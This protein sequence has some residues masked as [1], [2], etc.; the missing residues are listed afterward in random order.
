M[1]G[2]SAVSLVCGLLTA[3]SLPCRR[4]QLLEAL[5]RARWGRLDGLGALVLTPTR[6]LAMQVQGEL[7][8]LYKEAGARIASCVGGMDSRAEQ[9]MLA[10]GAHIVVGTPGRLRDH[11]ERGRLDLGSLRVAV[12]DGLC[13]GGGGARG[14]HGG[15][16]QG[17]RAEVRVHGARLGNDGGRDPRVGR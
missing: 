17:D 8:W 14:E 12:L 13:R 6:E 4:P 7:T 16:E 15:G 3:A 9:R 10:A 2:K 11:L 1:L 5:F